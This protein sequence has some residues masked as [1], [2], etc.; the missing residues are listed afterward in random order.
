VDAC[1]AV[2]NQAQLHRGASSAS[3]CEMSRARAGIAV[4]VERR[5]HYPPREWEE[6]P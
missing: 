6:N 1:F 2:A 4:L 5:F 3:F